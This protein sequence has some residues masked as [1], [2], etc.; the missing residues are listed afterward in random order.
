M[1]QNGDVAVQRLRALVGNWGREVVSWKL[2]LAEEELDA[3]LSGESAMDADTRQRSVDVWQELA[4]DGAGGDDTEGLFAEPS[5]DDLDQAL[6]AEEAEE[7]WRRVEEEDAEVEAQSPSPP[8]SRATPEVASEGIELSAL[9]G[10]AG[11]E[12]QERIEMSLMDSHLR[13]SLAQYGQG[14]SPADKVNALIVTVKLEVALITHLRQSFPEAG[15]TRGAERRAREIE[16]RQKRLTLLER[17]R[18]QHYFGRR[19]PSDEEVYQRIIEL[20]EP[21]ILAMESGSDPKIIER[22]DALMRPE[23]F[24]ALS[25]RMS[26]ESLRALRA[27]RAL[28]ADN[29]GH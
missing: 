21:M 23:T 27:F 5:K 28:R 29:Q 12:Q 1:E 13:A 24:R 17:V 3:V 20:S 16:K 6:I 18:D 11:P 9:P 4:G 19:I 15:H 8:Q 25:A 2:G 26:P 7:V 22:I 14:A 10:L